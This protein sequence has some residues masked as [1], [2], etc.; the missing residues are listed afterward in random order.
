MCICAIGECTEP[1][2][3]RRFK[4]DNLFQ[5]WNTRITSYNVCYTKL[6]R[7]L[8]VLE[9]YRVSLAPVAAAQKVN[10]NYVA[11]QNVSNFA[12]TPDSSAAIYMANQT[13]SAVQLYRVPFSMLQQSNPSYNFV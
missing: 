12:I 2:P 1:D 7:T 8:G 13:N 11:G 6:L 9:L 5:V 10:P 3:S 4:I